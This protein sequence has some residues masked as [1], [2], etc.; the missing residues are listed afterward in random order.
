MVLDTSALI[1]IFFNEPDRDALVQA[2]IE[3]PK[4]LMSVANVLEAS[5]VL[6]ARRG[7]AGGRELDLFLHDVG[8]ELVAVDVEQLE[9][10]RLAYRRYGKG[11]SPAGLNF[12]DCFSYAL[13]KASGELLLAKGDDFKK[14]D[15]ALAVTE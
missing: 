4:K 11:R 10:A 8:V 1:A 5:I 14:T 7:D 3:S 6:E 13:A 15:I 12:G 2:V 9:L